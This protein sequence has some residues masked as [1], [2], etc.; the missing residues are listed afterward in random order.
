[1]T[2]VS[3]KRPPLRELLALFRSTIAR[4]GVTTAAGAATGDSIIDAGLIGFGANS[5]FTMLLIVYPGQQELVD[6][7]DITAFNNATGEIDMST[8]YK[9]VAAAIPVGVPYIIV[10]FKFVPAEVAALTALVTALMA[11][12]GDP[13]GETI[14]NLAD[15]FGDIARSLDLMLGDRWDAAGDLGTDITTILAALTGA[16]GGFNEQAD[17]AINEAVTAAEVFIITFT[18]ATT[19]YILRDLRIKSED[20]TQPNNITVK[21]YTLINDVEINVQSFVITNTNFGTYFSLMDMFGV[22]HVAGD[23]I[24]VSLQGSAAGPYT[25]T[26]QYSH[27]KTNV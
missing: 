7:M 27:G 15:R 11:D 5:F 26:G 25:V 14:D 10:T 21:L 6:S 12:V 3:N 18:A 4:Q 22:P 13:T 20:P 9:G 23:S 17:V 2:S 19:R 16:T 24:R 1:M 8:A